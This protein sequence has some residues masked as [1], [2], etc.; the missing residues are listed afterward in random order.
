[1]EDK[2]EM[3]KIKENRKSY[4]IKLA[5]HVHYREIKMQ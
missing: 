2:E 5:Y 3:K 1:M 4:V